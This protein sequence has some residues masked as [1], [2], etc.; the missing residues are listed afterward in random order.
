MGWLELISVQEFL[1]RGRSVYVGVRSNVY[2]FTVTLLLLLLMVRCVAQE[3]TLNK[4]CVCGNPGI[5]G[6][7][8]TTAHLAETLEMD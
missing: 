3:E 6:T 5:L 2:R 8:D 4:G 1:Q 7:P